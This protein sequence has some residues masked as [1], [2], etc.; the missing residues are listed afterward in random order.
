MKKYFHVFKTTLIG[1]IQYFSNLTV[2]LVI[3]FLIIFILL[4]IW[5]Y[6]YSD[7]VIVNG[8]TSNQIMWYVL[9]AEAFCIGNS[10]EVFA[11]EMSYDIKSG[12]IACKINK[13]YNY[14]FFSLSK[15]L[16]DVIVK[17]LFFISI[18]I[19]TGITFIGKI[20]NFNIRNI[21]LL[22]L[23]Y[24]LGIIINSLINIV[25]NLSSF[26]IEENKPVRWVYEKI[27]LMFGVMFPLE[28]L[29]IWLQPVVKFTPVF[30]CIYGPI[31]LTVDFSFNVFYRIIATQFLYL[32]G[33]AFFA[34]FIYKKGV[35]KINA[36]GG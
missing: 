6:V 23:V 26:W 11:N 7:R 17:I 14:V 34:L 4:N 16:G 5:T 31:K 2:E 13:P 18:G 27:I 28:M 12:N 8:Y 30:T 25:V 20:Q 36:N 35:R 3:F 15:Y 10:N 33:F 9:L 19:I 29:P 1:K 22:I 32:V 21:L 24:I